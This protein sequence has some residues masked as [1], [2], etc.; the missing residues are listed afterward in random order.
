M[1]ALISGFAD[2]AFE[3]RLAHALEERG[4][5]YEA[6][7]EAAKEAV[8]ARAAAVLTDSEIDFAVRAG[9]PTRAFTSAG[10]DEAAVRHMVAAL[11]DTTSLSPR[12]TTNEVAQLL[13]RDPANVRRMHANGDLIA[14]GQSDRQ[15]TYPA[16]QFTADDRVLPHLRR[17][18]AAFPPDFHARDIEVVMTSPMEDLRGRSPKQWLE[19]DGA[20][21]VLMPLLEDLALT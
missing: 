4:V 6:V 15:T 19:A 7:T 16:W 8:G 11:T 18:V 10:H 12:L 13:G 21:D 1:A 14:A 9:V 5:S 17:V 20:I 2:S 3:A